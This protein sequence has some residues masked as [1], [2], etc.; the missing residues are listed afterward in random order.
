MT[1]DLLEERNTRPVLCTTHVTLCWGPESHC[2]IDAKTHSPSQPGCCLF[3][4][5]SMLIQGLLKSFRALGNV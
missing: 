5:D 1:T 3:P 4:R 2:N